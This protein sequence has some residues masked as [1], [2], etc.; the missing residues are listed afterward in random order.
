MPFFKYIKAVFY[1]LLSDVLA[2][3]FSWKSED[4]NNKIK[5]R[6]FFCYCFTSLLFGARERK[7]DLVSLSVR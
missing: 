1:M 6:N 3:W 7:G 5:M 2:I 4:K